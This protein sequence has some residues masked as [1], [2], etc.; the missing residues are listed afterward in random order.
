MI[1]LEGVRIAPTPPLAAAAQTR[2]RP[3]GAGRAGDSAMVTALGLPPLPETGRRGHLM[4]QLT[5]LKPRQGARAPV[6]LTQSADGPCEQTG[7]RLEDTPWDLGAMAA[8]AGLPVRCRSAAR[9]GN[10]L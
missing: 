9:R 4:F 5:G 7:G 2:Y 1:A 3:C 8:H 10:A 6:A